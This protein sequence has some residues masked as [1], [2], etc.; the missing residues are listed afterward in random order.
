MPHMERGRLLHAMIAEYGAW[1]FEHDRVDSSER[2]AALIAGRAEDEAVQLQFR[3]FCE[4]TVWEWASVIGTAG[5]LFE[6]WHERELPDGLGVFVGRVDLLMLQDNLLTVHDWKSGWT[7][8]DQPEHPTT[9]LL[10]Y[11]WLLADKFSATVDTIVLRQEFAGSGALWSWDV[12]PWDLEEVE[13]QLC[14]E[15]REVGARREAGDWPLEPGT[16]CAGCGFRASCA[17]A[18]AFPEVGG[19]L[20]DLADA[21]HLYAAAREAAND[22]L[23]RNARANGPW[24]D[25]DGRA[26]FWHQQEDKVEVAEGRHEDLVG[27]LAL[28]KKRVSSYL[29]LDQRG[30]RLLADLEGYREFIAVKPG[31]QRWGARRLATDEDAAEQVMMPGV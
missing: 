5:N 3:R 1:C 16:Y 11:A 4:R 7:D 28:G 20:Q 23:Q 10:R 21:V 17:K 31:G 9:Q 15:V 30:G 6:T 13:E 24:T 22:A 26:W 29:K 18:W 14:A 8:A 27:A 25:R 2:A 12:Y 19:S